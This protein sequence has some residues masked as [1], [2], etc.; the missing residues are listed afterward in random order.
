MIKIIFIIVILIISVIIGYLIK[1]YFSIRRDL[2]YDFKDV[3]QLLKSE[4]SFLKSSKLEILTGRKFKTKYC[5]EFIDR[6]VKNEE[7]C[8]VY[9]NDFEIKELLIMLDSIGNSDVD[10]EIN[11]I[12]YC[13]I[14]IEKF[15]KKAEE[16]F[17]KYGS[18]SFKISFILG[19]LI[20]I[21]LI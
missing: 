13:E 1:Q 12:N 11:N 15:C 3:F 19:V 7:I 9:L 14:K 21:I 5:S 8:C 2:F 17:N 4:I 16:N 6:Y 10:G 20:S 18:F